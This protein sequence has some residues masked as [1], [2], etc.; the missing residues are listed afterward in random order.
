MISTYLYRL[1]S[2]NCVVRWYICRF[3]WIQCFWNWTWRMWNLHRCGILNRFIWRKC[4][5]ESLGKRCQWH[6]SAVGLLRGLVMFMK[7]FFHY[8]IFRVSF[9]VMCWLCLHMALGVHLY[10][11]L[12]MWRYLALKVHLDMTLWLCLHVKFRVSLNMTFYWIG[13]VYVTG[14]LLLLWCDR[15]ILIPAVWLW[16]SIIINTWRSKSKLCMTP[17]VVRTPNWSTVTHFWIL[18]ITVRNIVRVCWVQFWWRVN[19]HTGVGRPFLFFWNFFTGRIIAT[20][21][22]IR[23]TSH[24]AQWFKTLCM[25]FYNFIV[26]DQIQ[27]FH[28]LLAYFTKLLGKMNMF[29]TAFIN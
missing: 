24:A 23:H 11:S 20:G 6:I 8:I 19:K 9:D 21:I 10:I 13:S 14:L 5:A 25:K 26:C 17:M 1:T 28:Q 3:I 15:G 22:W 16:W 4:L 2:C 12:Q 7:M 18:A 27:I 29:S